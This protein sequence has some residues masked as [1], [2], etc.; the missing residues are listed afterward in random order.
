MALCFFFKKTL[1]CPSPFQSANN[2]KKKKSKRKSA[3][4]EENETEAIEK[5]AQRKTEA[6][7][8]DEQME[9][10]TAVWEARLVEKGYAGGRYHVCAEADAPVGRGSLDPLIGVGLALAKLRSQVEREITVVH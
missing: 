2:I 5:Q 7:V 1:F 6:T 10:R 3:A 9:K 8:A 4:L